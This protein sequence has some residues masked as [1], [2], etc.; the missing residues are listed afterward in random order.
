MGENKKKKK[1]TD[2]GGR[3]DKK[4]PLVVVKSL[5]INVVKGKKMF[6]LKSS[7]FLSFS[8]KLV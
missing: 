8:H 6:P 5:D 7:C 1:G 3:K 4:G 2:N